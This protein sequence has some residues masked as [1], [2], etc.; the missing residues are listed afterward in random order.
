MTND[1]LLPLDGR[2]LGVDLGEVRVGLAISD[3]GQV[4]A[5][6][7]ATCVVARNDMQAMLN[8]VID[9]VYEHAAVG[10]VVGHPRQLDGRD[11]AKASMTRRFVQAL[12]DAVKLP[13]VLIDERFS[14]VEAQ[15]LLIDADV[16]RAKRKTVID[17]V[18]AS[19]VLQHALARQRMRRNDL[20]Q[21][22]A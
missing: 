22:Q 17:Q 13:V 16:S 2:L 4:I 19:V 3:P 20:N 15:R 18:A 14:T 11:G 12:T 8:V 21:S 7:A 5:Q 10:I 6:V 1:A 9:A